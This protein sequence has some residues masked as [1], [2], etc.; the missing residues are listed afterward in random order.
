MKKLL[1]LLLILCML[2]AVLPGTGAEQ[3]YPFTVYF[4]D[5]GQGDCA[6]V[7]ADGHAMIIDGG[8]SAYSSYVYR[9][10]R[11]KGIRHLDCMVATH[12]DADHVGGLAGALFAATPDVVLCTVAEAETPAFSDLLRQ[13]DRRG[14]SVTV[15]AEG[16]SFM[17]GGAEVQ[18]IVPRNEPVSGS[19]SSLVIRITYGSRSFLFTGD[20]ENEDENKLLEAG[21]PLKSDVLKVGH[22]G[23]SSSTG[24]PFLRA[25]SP[26]YAVISVGANTFHHPTEKTLR[27][28]KSCRV[29]L[30]RTDIQGLITCRSDGSELVFSVE[31]NIGLN[32]YAYVGGYKK[33]KDALGRRTYPTPQPLRSPKPSESPTYIGNANPN[34]EKHVFHLPECKSVDTIKEKNKRVCVATREEMLEAGYVPCGRC[35]P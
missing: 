33:S 21:V 27:A 24:M 16:F 3:E 31:K 35:N 4:L 19:N 5:V 34:S 20:S 30:Y 9:F 14:L 13:L 12:P 2:F 7:V 29:T 17:L 1:S 11:E 10:L 22:H 18:V 6:V 25:V 15:P 28:L 26:E 8:D 32:T 23:S